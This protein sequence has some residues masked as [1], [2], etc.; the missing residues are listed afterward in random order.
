MPASGCF[1]GPE[2]GGTDAR[3]VARP[4]RPR[5]TSTPTSDDW[6]Y[7]VSVVKMI[8]SFAKEAAREKIARVA[9]F[10]ECE[11]YAAHRSA[12]RLERRSE[13]AVPASLSQHG[14]AVIAAMVS[15][16]YTD[17]EKTRDPE[18]WHAARTYLTRLADD[19]L[20]APDRLRNQAAILLDAAETIDRLLRWYEARRA[21]LKT[22]DLTNDTI[23]AIMHEWKT[24][25]RATAEA[26]TAH[27]HTVMEG[28]LKAAVGRTSGLGRRRGNVEP[29]VFYIP[30]LQRRQVTS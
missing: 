10:L 26:L 15:D 25:P 13:F 29:I 8:E 27:G 7:A 4:A 21:V 11:G 24:K 3:Y 12:D 19:G 1:L 5:E 16:C 20:E 9:R 22:R 28:A 6:R 14:R 18:P 30:G 23:V 17:D 2:T